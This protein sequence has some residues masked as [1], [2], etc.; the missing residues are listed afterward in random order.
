MAR[1]AVATLRGGGGCS[2]SLGLLILM[3]ER[4]STVHPHNMS[5]IANSAKLALKLILTIESSVRSLRMVLH[6]RP[7]LD[8]IHELSINKSGRIL[9]ERR[10]DVMILLE[11]KRVV[12]YIFLQMVNSKTGKPLV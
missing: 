9:A 7:V 1:G 3:G 11:S 2:S 5:R 12:L 8:K 6:S 4:S 10:S